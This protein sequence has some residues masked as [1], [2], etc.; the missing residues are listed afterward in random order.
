MG[1]SGDVTRRWFEEVWN[2][3]RVEAI[4]ELLTPDATIH[5]LAPGELTGPEAFRAFHASFTANFSDIHVT[6]ERTLE[7]GDGVSALCSVV[8]THRD[9]GK[10]VAFSGAVMGTVRDGRL[11]EGWNSWDFLGLLT[12]L[13]AV[14]ADAVAP[15]LGA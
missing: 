10:A 9:S 8:A 13:G 11:H 1:E 12:Q 5:G 3:G 7:D 14:D 4:D 2:Q 6:V 15:L